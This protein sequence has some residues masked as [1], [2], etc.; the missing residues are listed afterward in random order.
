[1]WTNFST[2]TKWICASCETT[3]DYPIRTCE[4]CGST[5]IDE[6]STNFS[7]GSKTIIRLGDE[8]EDEVDDQDDE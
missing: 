5:S 1:M 4:E 2:E 6:F 7:T 8:D 3:Y